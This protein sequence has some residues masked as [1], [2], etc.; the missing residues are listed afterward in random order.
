LPERGKERGKRTM[1]LLRVATPFYYVL[2][3]V[4]A[5]I[6]FCLGSAE[7]RML[8]SNELL[9]GDWDLSIRCDPAWFDSELFPPRQFLAGSSDNEDGTIETKKHRLGR[10][11]RRHHPCHLQVFPNGTFCLSPKQQQLDIDK[12][13]LAVSGRWKVR[14]NPYCVTDRFYDEIVLTSYPRVQK[15]ITPVSPDINQNVLKKG[16]IRMQCQ[17][18]GHFSAGRLTRRFCKNSAYGKGSLSRGI[19]LWENRA[20]PNS[21]PR[22]F[23]AS[24]SG[25]RWIPS[26][27]VINSEDDKDDDAG[28]DI[29]DQ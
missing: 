16:A 21:I 27:S 24:F 4:A 11:S 18:S 25:R 6:A 13:I 3:L 1:G 28:K 7:S 9:V 29:A 23:R 14:P 19:L 10:F 26:L 15:K 17:M 2:P 22:A 8:D 12:N 20:S 5:G